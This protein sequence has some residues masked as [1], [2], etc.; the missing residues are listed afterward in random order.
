ME[1]FKGTSVWE[2]FWEIII[3]TSVWEQFQGII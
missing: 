3:G 1:K 2:Q